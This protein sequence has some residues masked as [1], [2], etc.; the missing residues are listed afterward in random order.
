MLKTHLFLVILVHFTL[1]YVLRVIYICYNWKV[2]ILCNDEHLCFT[3]H[4][5]TSQRQ[6]EMSEGGSNS[7]SET[8]QCYIP[9]LFPPEI[10]W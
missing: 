2:D 1:I 9:G 6:L 8:G 5:V 3:Q 10:L 7:T 4:S